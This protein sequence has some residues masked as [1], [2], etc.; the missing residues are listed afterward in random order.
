MGNGTTTWGQAPSSSP[1]GY[2]NIWTP[3]T[4]TPYTTPPLYSN[5]PEAV[6]PSYASTV[7]LTLTKHLTSVA[8]AT[9]PP[10]RTPRISVNH[11]KSAPYPIPKS[12][13]GTLSATAPTGHTG[14]IPL[15]TGG[16]NATRSTSL[17]TF[18]STESTS[19]HTT[20]SFVPAANPEAPSS[21]LSTQPYTPT[22]LPTSQSSTDASSA[23]Q[24]GL[25]SS[26]A[27]A[28]SS[29]KPLGHTTVVGISVGAAACA[30]LVVAGLVMFFI[31]K[32]RKR[33]NST[34]AS[35]DA[36]AAWRGRPLSTEFNLPEDYRGSFQRSGEPRNDI[37][38]GYGHQPYTASSAGFPTGAAG[39]ANV[40]E[41]E[42]PPMAE[43]VLSPEAGNAQGGL[44]P[45]QAHD[46]QAL[47]SFT[48]FDAAQENPNTPGTAFPSATP[49]PFAHPLDS[50]QEAL[51]RPRVAPPSSVYDTSPT[52]GRIRSQ[53]V[54]NNPFD[55]PRDSKGYSW[56]NDR[57]NPGSYMNRNTGAGTD[58]RSYRLERIQSTDL[59]EAIVNDVISDPHIVGSV[60]GAHISTASSVYGLDPAARGYPRVSNP[61]LSRLD[62]TQTSSRCTQFGD[63]GN[64]FRSRFENSPIQEDNSPYSTRFD[65]FID[66][67]KTT[68]PRRGAD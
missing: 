64:G 14:H 12:K 23:D 56:I 5:S 8:F 35:H 31:R 45:P 25:A 15:T 33:V 6:T 2:T 38:G 51:P 68:N 28:V 4:S 22:S 61:F 43:R 37:T 47:N 21:Q 41:P 10:L 7:H 50:A 57:N 9:Q 16:R 53:A 30:A 24:S 27:S 40:A 19:S 17:V 65:D 20:S 34:T 32:Q 46:R 18:Y 60:A 39:G 66:T 48:I 49:N 42:S 26:S 3:S 13:N 29:T 55:K 54:S 63:A 36:S 1:Q 59:D 67:Q 62:T 44:A 52:T 58:Q 11:T